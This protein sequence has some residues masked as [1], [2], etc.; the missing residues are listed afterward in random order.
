MTSAGQMCSAMLQYGTAV[1]C[2][3]SAAGPCCP[4]PATM[5]ELPQSG[6]WHPLLYPPLQIKIVAF[7]SVM[8]RSSGLAQL[9][10]RPL[11]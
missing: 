1:Q 9:L 10:V 8:G 2:S 4:P 6:N 5:W 3:G 7:L 11:P